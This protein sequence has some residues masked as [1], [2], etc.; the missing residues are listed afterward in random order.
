MLVQRG[1]LRVGDAVV[2][3]AQWGKVRAMLDHRGERVE[4]ATPGMP[5]E[6]LGFD[7]V[8]DAGEHVQVVDNERVAR[9]QAQERETRLKSEASSRA[10]RP[11]RSRWR[12]SSRRPARASCR[13]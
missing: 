12:R 6:V 9:Q 10:A 1:T 13:S 8:A 4:E 5:V 2:A 11:A 3:G 7:G